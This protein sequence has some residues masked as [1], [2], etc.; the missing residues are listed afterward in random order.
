M[1]LDSRI[2]TCSCFLKVAGIPES[3]HSRISVL[4]GYS[5]VLEYLS[6]FMGIPEPQHTHGVLSFWNYR[7][8]GMTASLK[9][10]IEV[11]PLCTSI[12][13]WPFRGRPNE[14]GEGRREKWV[15]EVG[16]VT[17]DKMPEKTE[18]RPDHI[19]EAFSSSHPLGV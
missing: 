19:R 5:I 16:Q 18:R 4:Q 14:R 1:Y 3:P 12:L 9:P 17:G 10:G 7:N 15:C 11:L 13:E 8:S 2:V 6:V